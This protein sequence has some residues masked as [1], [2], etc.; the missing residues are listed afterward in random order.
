MVV[1][2]REGDALVEQRALCE[3]LRARELV[4][5]RGEQRA[6]GLGRA[7]PV[8]R[9]G[10]RRARRTCLRGASTRTGAA[11]RSDRAAIGAVLTARAPRLPAA[12]ASDGRLQS[13]EGRACRARRACAVA[14][15]ACDRVRRLPLDREALRAPGARLEARERRRAVGRVPR[16]ATR[17]NAHAPSDRFAHVSSDVEAKRVMDAEVRVQAVRRR[18]GAEAHAADV[19]PRGARRAK[20]QR[21]AVDHHDVPLG[22][23]PFDAHLDALHRRVDE[24][25]GPG[26]RR[27]LAEDVPRLDGVA[28]LEAHVPRLE[29][30]DD[31]AAVLEERAVRVRAEGRGPRRSRW[32]STS[33]K[34]RQ[35]QVGKRK[36]SWST[37]PQ[38][39]SGA[40]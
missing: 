10:P 19:L 16:G 12:P 34:S 22:H 39:T 1:V 24:A 6:R 14:G 2:D 38:R 20:R 31:R 8:R 35:S 26:R 3:R 28:E 18:P 15:R 7:S 40:R 37:C 9:R 32:A 33:S 30:A 13:G 17:G 27:L 21:V 11:G 29:R 23:E 25:R 36:R 5:V 4:G